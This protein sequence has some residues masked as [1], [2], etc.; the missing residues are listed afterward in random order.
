MSVKDRIKAYAKSKGISVRK[1]EQL[2][3]LNNGYVN[4]IRVSMQPDKIQSISSYFTDLNIDWLMTGEGEMLKKKDT[5]EAGV[6]QGEVRMPSDT[7][8][9]IQQ[10]QQT[11]NSQQRTI[12][13]L[14]KKIPGDIVETA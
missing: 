12:E 2:S 1:L 3:G 10:L 6:Q 8:Q 4:G 7:W 9:M 11:I 13:I 14:S 5:K